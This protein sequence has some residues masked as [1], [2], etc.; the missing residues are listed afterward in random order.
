VRDAVDALDA[1]DD[2]DA[3]LGFAAAVASSYVGPAASEVCGLSVQVHGGIGFTWE[4]DA[5]LC[6]KRAKLDEAWF[7][8][9]AWH[10]RRI[11]DAVFPA[12]VAR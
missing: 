6:L 9:P 1:P 5:H 11:A 10:R 4:H 2:P 7:G 3:D 12:R 8:T